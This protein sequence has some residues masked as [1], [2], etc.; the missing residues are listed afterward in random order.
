MEYGDGSFIGHFFEDKIC[1]DLGECIEDFMYLAVNDLYNIEPSEDTDGI[2][3]WARP[4][5][6][7][8]LNPSITPNSET[9]RFMLEAMSDQQ[10]G[11]DFTTRFRT[12]YV[13]W[14]DIGGYS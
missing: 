7:M 11:S 9:T 5:Q 2:F 8:L 3:G 10:F 12:G 6:P 13:S 14:I 4:Y 1:L